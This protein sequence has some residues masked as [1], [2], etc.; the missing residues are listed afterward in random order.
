MAL[1]TVLT[2]RN[3]YVYGLLIRFSEAYKRFRVSVPETISLAMGLL[4]EASGVACV[5]LNEIELLQRFVQ[6]GTAIIE[7]GARTGMT[8][9]LLSG[10]V[11]QSGLVLAVEPNPLAFRLLARRTRKFSNVII[12]N[13]AL[14]ERDGITTLSLDS[15]VGYG[16]SLVK[17]TKRQIRVRMITMDMLASLLHF[18]NPDIIILDTEGYEEKI[19][20]GSQE[21]LK[22]TRMLLV[23]IHEFMDP[24]LQ[25]RINEIA[26]SAGFTK[27]QTKIES[28]TP[29]ITTT[30]YTKIATQ[31]ECVKGH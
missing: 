3:S 25:K 14:G 16:A 29:I 1:N 19:L 17:E 13:V 28:R 27:V 18:S 22:R 31:Y 6:E 20:L 30:L 2:T 24:L 5:E 11:G 12:V 21:L 4:E 9:K 7:V 23:E 8:T 26:T 10:M 15:A